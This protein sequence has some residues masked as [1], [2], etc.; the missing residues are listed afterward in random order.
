M[1]ALV[2]CVCNAK[3]AASWRMKKWEQQPHNNNKV[4]KKK[5]ITEK[6]Y[7]KKMV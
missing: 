4:Y 6:N 1:N 7:N 2:V 3:C 5:E